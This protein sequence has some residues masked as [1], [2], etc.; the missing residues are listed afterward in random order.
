MITEIHNKDDRLKIK[1]LVY[2]SDKSDKKAPPAPLP[3]SYSNFFIF[4]G[5]PGSGKSTLMLNMFCSKKK[6]LYKKFDKIYIFSPS[7]LGNNLERKH[8]IFTLPPEQLFD[9]L[10]DETFDIFLEDI[11]DTEDRVLVVFDD[12]QTEMAKGSMLSKMK[13]LIFNRRHL[14]E[15]GV[16]IFISSQVYNNIPL[17]LRKAC[18]HLFLFRTKNLKEIE[19]VRL[20]L[21]NHKTEEEFS[22]LL[23]FCFKKKHDFLLTDIYSSYEDRVYFY[24][25]FNKILFT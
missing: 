18:S 24:H 14:T 21:T 10:N 6:F 11:R 20:E 7:L 25:N 3:N 5:K 19:N 15:G 13:K 16:Q 12:C 2:S 23:E 1:P 22:E 4:I 9:E 17:A 8:P